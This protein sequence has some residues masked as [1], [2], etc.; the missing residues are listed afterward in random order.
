M[1][2]KAV[3]NSARD[4]KR[5]IEVISK[6]C[7]KLKH[8]GVAVA[9]AYSTTKTNGLYVFGD[10]RINKVIEDH[11]DDV[12]LNPDWMKDEDEVGS[13]NTILLPPL[14]DTLQFLNGITM[15]ALIRGI[16]KDLKLNWDSEKPEWWPTDVPF[17]NVTQAASDYEG[18]YS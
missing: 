13:L 4:I 7:E 17:Q 10:Q 8:L 2:S 9:V 5:K 6:K 11:K 18:M 1:S 3:N 16:M 12:L 15:K 14:P